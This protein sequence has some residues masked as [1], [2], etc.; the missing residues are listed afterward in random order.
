MLQL[1]Q[2]LH[3][4]HAVVCYRYFDP[5]KNNKPGRVELRLTLA[6]GVLLSVLSANL[7]GLA[8]LVYAR[9]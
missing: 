8:V 7:I 1:F 6:V 9:K 2:S 3:M 4:R 5:V